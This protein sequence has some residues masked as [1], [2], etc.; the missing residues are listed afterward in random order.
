MEVLLRI[1]S[2][3]ILSVFIDP[4]NEICELADDP[5]TSVIS[6]RHNRL[7]NDIAKIANFFSN[8]GSGWVCARAC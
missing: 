7:F 8:E 3:L 5:K 2:L 6:I 1:L 4:N